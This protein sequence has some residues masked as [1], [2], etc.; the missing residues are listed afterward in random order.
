MSL[1]NAALDP[2]GS[3]L[4]FAE[5]FEVDDGPVF[6]GWSGMV[7]P[8]PVPERVARATGGMAAHYAS[9]GA[10][11]AWSF[12]VPETWHGY[13]IGVVRFD[14]RRS[15]TGSP[16]PA[17]DVRLVS[18]NASLET[19]LLPPPADAWTHYD[20]DLTSPSAWTFRDSSG[21]RPAT[22]DD[23]RN[24]I[25]SAYGL[26]IRGQAFTASSDASLDNLSVELFH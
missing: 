26:A 12:V 4:V 7:T 5:D 16:V 10:D 6:I 11:P 8:A 14:L 2:R 24:A 25:D 19:T 15:G 20:L 1:D 22:A 17:A 13:D 23:L 3:F 9:T 21:T 18:V